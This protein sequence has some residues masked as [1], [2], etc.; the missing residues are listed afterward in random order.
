M[1]TGFTV[2]NALNK[3][4]KAGIEDKP[5]ARFRT[6][7][8]SIFNIYSNSENFYP[9]EGI[10]E[11]AGE[12]LAVGLL[13]NLVVVYEPNEEG[14]EYKLISGERRWRGLHLLHERG[15]KEFEIVTCQIRAVKSKYEEKVELIIANSSRTKSEALIAR[16]EKELKTLLEHMKANKIELKGYDLQKGRLR[17]V[18]AEILK[19][20]STKIG[21]MDSINNKLIKEFYKEFE[22]EKI[23]FSAAYEL[24]KKSEEEQRELYKK[25]TES[26]GVTYTELK[27]ESECVSESDTE[28]SAYLE[29]YEE[30]DDNNEYESDKDSNSINNENS[31]NNNENCS[32]GDSNNCEGAAEES[33]TSGC[34]SE[35]DTEKEFEPTPNKIVSICYS[36]KNWN[37]CGEKSNV[38]T[39]C[40]EYINKAEAEKTEEQKYDEEQ[41]KLDKECKRKLEEMADEEKMNNLPS[42]K[43]ENE[44]YRYKVASSVFTEIKNGTRC[45]DV[46]KK[47]KD[48]KTGEK[49][50]MLEFREGRHTGNVIKAEITL[51]LEECAGIEDGYC[52]IG[53]KV[54]GE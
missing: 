49:M 47:I 40:N 48:Y 2:M 9:Q 54:L 53:F 6:K 24:S 31:D 17:D 26:E 46:R 39:E 37:E 23:S 15:Y 11:K 38:V 10:E 19:K 5:Q 3:N 50:E 34:V 36:C 16:E 28:E 33:N 1:A 52:V 51:V 27:K 4:T 45:F 7:D 14:K 8:I 25:H 42:D 22:E 43:A 13:E 35:S 32:I 21:Q 12:I 41:A 29:E 30:Y 44:V 20:S 18:I